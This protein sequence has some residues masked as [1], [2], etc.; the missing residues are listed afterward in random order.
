VV[1]LMAALRASVEAARSGRTGSAPSAG[2][3]ESGPGERAKPIA[4]EPAKAPAKKAAAKKTAAKTAA[5][6]PAKKAPA[7]KAARRTA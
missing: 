4:K 2:D 3:R 7:K 5:K 6:A 1:D